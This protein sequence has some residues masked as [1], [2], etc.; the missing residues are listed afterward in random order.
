M[1]KISEIVKVVDQQQLAPGV[2]SL[3]VKTAAAAQAAPGQFVSLYCG[4]NSR[5]LPR[6]I[7]ICEIDKEM[8][9]LR[10][11]YRVVGQGTEE[12][13]RLK[14]GDELRLV[15]PLGNGFPVKGE[16][17][18]LVGGGIGVP[19]MLEL[20]K[21]FGNKSQ[22]VLGYRDDHL[23]LRDDFTIACQV[24]SNRNTVPISIATDDGSVG[25]HG[26]VIDA[27]KANHITGD[28]IYACGPKPMLRG[29]KEYAAEAGIE[30]YISMEERMACGIG[31]CLGCVC[32]T[33]EVDDHSK[34][35]NARICKDGPVFKA[36]EVDLS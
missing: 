2:Y 35:H 11:V 18:I 5:L 4:D 23:F 3:W 28:V 16:K 19:P 7:S 32:K 14:A 27:I 31:A 10:M 24:N 29:L 30:C 15:G 34:V 25:V 17:P 21:S 36:E 8:G 9:V 13:S 26:T 22:V 6:P 12:F 20:A 33:T 1:S